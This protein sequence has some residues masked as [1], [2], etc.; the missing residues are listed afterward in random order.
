MNV[1]NQSPLYVVAFA[2]LLHASFQLGVGLLTLLSGHSLGSR[3]SFHRLMQLN[4][5]YVAG[6]SLVTLLLFAG[7]SYVALL[8][9]TTVLPAAWIVVA[10]LNIAIGGCVIAFYYRRN[11][12]TGLW[13]PRPMASYLQERTKKTK[14]SAEAFTLGAG[15]VLAE[16]PFLIAP[17]GVAILA[18]ISRSSNPDLQLGAFVLYCLI[19][20]MP[21]VA[22]VALV[23][24]GH[25]IST[26][27]RW[28]EEN[29]LFLQH[30]AGAGLVI[31][32]VYVLVEKVLPGLTP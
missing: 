11:S 13:I 19:G 30:C 9:I 17:L 29:K 5:A 1:L 3:R 32:G 4:L 14:H 28:R 25:K 15:S 24:S 23:G 18:V 7:L 27:Q 16:I 20:L 2:G 6:A 12:G 22:I 8:T 26:I 21:L 10:F 31:L